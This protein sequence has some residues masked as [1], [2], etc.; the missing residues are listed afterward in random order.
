MI[1]T[2]TANL[3]QNGFVVV[4]K[5]ADYILD[6]KF[7]FIDSNKTEVKNL[8]SSDTTLF[9][10]NANVVAELLSFDTKTQIS[11]FSGQEKGFGKTQIKSYYDLIQKVSATITDSL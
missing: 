9:I 6:I 1:K 4:E 8:Q 11:S 10:S 5:N 3:V 7:N 2:I